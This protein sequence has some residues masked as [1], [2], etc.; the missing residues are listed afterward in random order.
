MEWVFNLYM[1][2][3][4]YQQ[5]ADILNDERIPFSQDARLW[6]KHKIKRL[7]E[8]PRYTGKDGYPA[9]VNAAAFQKVQERIREKT[10][11]YTVRAERPQAEAASPLR[12]L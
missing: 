2:K 3:L 12:E 9:L 4:S 11:G 7:L 1:V 6:N 8:N 10:A 5:A